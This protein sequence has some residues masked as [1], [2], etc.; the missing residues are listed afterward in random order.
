[1]TDNTITA[2]SP[3]SLDTARVEPRL[4]AQLERSKG[5]LLEHESV[6]TDMLRGHDTIQEDRDD[7]RRVVEAIR[8]DVQQIQGA[9]ARLH[10]GTY[11]RCIT[12]GATIAH[13]R[14]E[15]IPTVAQCAR[16]A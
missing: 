1:M 8:E 5:Q 6:L 4:L 3:S 14:L 12:C 16:C 7:T 9:L 15:A 2:S 10:D 11:G 13:E